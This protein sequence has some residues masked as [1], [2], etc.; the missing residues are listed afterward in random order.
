M[1]PRRP[2]TT[3]PAPAPA[4]APAGGGT[5]PPARW[6]DIVGMIAM[7]VL[8]IAI[9]GAIYAIWANADVKTEVGVIKT[10]INGVKA[11]VAGIKANM[12]GMK[13]GIDALVK[14]TEKEDSDRTAAAE[15]ATAAAARAAGED[16]VRSMA[17]RETARSIID[18]SFRCVTEPGGLTFEEQG[19]VALTAAPANDAVVEELLRELIGDEPGRV[20]KASEALWVMLPTMSQKMREEIAHLAYFGHDPLLRARLVKVLLR[21]REVER[22]GVTNARGLIA[23]QKA[24]QG[25]LTIAQRADAATVRNSGD[26]K[27][28]RTDTDKDRVESSTRIG[29]LRKSLAEARAQSF[30]ELAELKN[31]LAE[32]KSALWKAP[33]GEFVKLSVWAKTLETRISTLEQNL[34]EHVKL[35]CQQE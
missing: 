20:R 15:A 8:V 9:I 32:V 12:S 29:E 10:D 1:A 35:P 30:A 5:T 13:T 19:L 11:D 18:G 2:R 33:E 23:T 25:V 21:T 4:P 6:K 26:I 34:D 28:L 16:R 22:Q 7:A 31:S 14:R 17:G 24:T 3:P 27:K